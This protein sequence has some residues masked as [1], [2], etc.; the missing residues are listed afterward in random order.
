MLYALKDG[1]RIRARPGIVAFCPCC[2]KPLISKCGLQRVWHWSHFRRPDCDDWYEP[3]TEWHLNWKKLTNP[4]CCEVRMDGHRADILG[5]NDTIIELQHSSISAPVIL[6]REAF[7]KKMIWLVDAT[8]FKNNFKIWGG[9][10]SG[11]KHQYIRYHFDWHRGRECWLF[12]RMPIF[13]DFGE[14]GIEICQYQRTDEGKWHW[15][16]TF[17]IKNCLFFIQRLNSKM[18]GYGRIV[19]KGDFMNKYIPMSVEVWD[20]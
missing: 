3:E 5:N 14:E 20:A 12:A 8:S 7:Y 2:Y 9:H 11:K 1:K 13:L 6:A 4:D 16:P 17:T 10:L 15:A 18:N 19:I